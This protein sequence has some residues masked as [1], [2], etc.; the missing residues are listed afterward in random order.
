MVE[1][2]DMAFENLVKEKSKQFAIRI[3]RLYQMLHETQNEY[4]LSKQ[5][6]RSGTSIGANIAEAV[7]AMSR[8]DFL[9]KL[10]VAYKECAETMYWLELLHDTD[11]LPESLFQSLYQDNLELYKLLTS[12]IKTTKKTLDQQ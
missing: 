6:L 8:K 3:V 2:E 1:V 4:V 10:Y 12:I 11:Y 9:A 5:V 7:C